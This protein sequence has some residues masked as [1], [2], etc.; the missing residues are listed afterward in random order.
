MRGRDSVIASLLV[1]IRPVVLILATLLTRGLSDVHFAALNALVVSIVNVRSLSFLHRLRHDPRRL[2]GPPVSIH[3]RRSDGTVDWRFTS[4][5]VG[6][7]V[8][9]GPSP[10]L[11]VIWRP[12]G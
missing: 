4:D 2:I 3:D 12:V 9:L 11:I 5:D 6:P 7:S 8:C 10:S 1:R